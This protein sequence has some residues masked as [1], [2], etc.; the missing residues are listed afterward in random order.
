MVLAIVVK[1]VYMAAGVG[2]AAAV[3][4]GLEVDGEAR[5]LLW[6]VALIGLANAVLV[7]LLRRLVLPLT[8]VT[9]GLSSLVV[10]GVLLPTTAGASDAFDVGSV[11][12]TLLAALVIST[13]TL[14]IGLAVGALV[15]EA[16]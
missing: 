5:S 6:I 8:V 11:S 13:V 2:V 12:A 16:A 14:L 10:N 7:P 9:L 3:T 1:L 15:D 4:P